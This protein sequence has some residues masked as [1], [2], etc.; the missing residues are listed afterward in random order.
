[1]EM[2]AVIE[3]LSSLTKPSQVTLYT[4]SE[5]V[6]KGITEWMD[7]WK[8]NNWTTSRGNSVKNQDLW[9]QMDKVVQSHEISW[10]WVKGH[11]GVEGNERADKL[12]R[13]F[14]ESEKFIKDDGYINSFKNEPDNQFNF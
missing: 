11:S 3:A 7:G 6:K 5:Y 1:M 10:N 2:L 13:A 9:V 4:D 14:A 12:A 8:K